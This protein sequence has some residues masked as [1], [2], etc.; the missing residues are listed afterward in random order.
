VR[1]SR[2]PLRDHLQGQFDEAEMRED[3]RRLIKVMRRVNSRALRQTVDRYVE[4]EV[5]ANWARTAIEA[6]SHMPAW[7]KRE[8]KQRCPGFLETEAIARA[9]NPAE[10]PPCRFGRFVK[11]IEG[12]EFAEAQKRG[13]FDVVRYEAHL[14]PRHARVV[15][16]WHDWEAE[17]TRHPS[18]KY[19]SLEQRR[20][21]ADSF[22]FDPGES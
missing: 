20:R 6:D 21:S 5:F 1:R 10:E 12:H 13:W 16:Y 14:R 15:D 19:P 3:H 11:W 18:A 17:R 8:V 2:Q 22:T 7:M 9:G 4:W